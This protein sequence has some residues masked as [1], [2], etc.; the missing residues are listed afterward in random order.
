MFEIFK[1]S[2][3]GAAVATSAQRPKSAVG[4]RKISAE[5]TKILVD[6]NEHYVG[7]YRSRLQVWRVTCGVSR[8][9]CH[10]WCVTCGVSRVACN[11][12]RFVGAGSRHEE[13]GGQTPQAAN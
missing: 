6:T 12:W 1:S 5:Q 3:S 9:A 4:G 2:Q 13:V 7:F 11:V 8:V 10:M